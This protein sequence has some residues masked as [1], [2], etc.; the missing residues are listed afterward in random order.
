MWITDVDGD[1]YML[2][3]DGT[4]PSGFKTSTYRNGEE[5]EMPNTKDSVD[6]KRE[7]ARESYEEER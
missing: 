5:K 4:E 3:M 1:A 7:A 2:H 6:E